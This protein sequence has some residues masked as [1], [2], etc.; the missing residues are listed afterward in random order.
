MPANRYTLDEILFIIDESD[1]VGSLKDLAKMCNRSEASL[2]YKFASGP[3]E[4]GR[5]SLRG[6]KQYNSMSQLY[7]AFGEVLPVDP[8][9]AAKD[10]LNRI[11]RFK[12]GLRSISE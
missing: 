5:N 9:E 12:S 3:L 11:E 4:D 6:I 2:R 1:R 7:K 10:I 8:K